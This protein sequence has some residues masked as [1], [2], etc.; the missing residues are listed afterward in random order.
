[1]TLAP[2][3]G[4]LFF[5]LMWNL[6]YYINQKRGINKNLKS[7]DDYAKLSTEKKLKVRDTLWE[8]PELIEEYIRENSDAHAAEELAIIQKWQ[9]FTKGTFYVFRHLKKGSIFIG[10]N[11]LVYSVHGIQDA[12]DDIIPAY[13]LPQMVQAV[14]LPF[15]GQIIYDGLLQGY[16]VHFGGGIRSD[17][18]HTYMVAKQKERIIT[19]LEPELTAP[20]LVKPKNTALPHLK[21]LS[22]TIAKIKGDGP[23]QSSALTLARLCL[24]VATADAEGILLQGEFET[25]TR[26]IVRASTRLRNLLDNL[27]ED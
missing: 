26:K 7:R 2:E 15:K 10:E 17:L 3:D 27:D 14:L 20:K 23:L 16:N 6:Q 25:Q 19:T 18:N 8:H 22:A 12:L 1:M 13:V 11:N 4:I 9:H 5:E 21:A 24:D